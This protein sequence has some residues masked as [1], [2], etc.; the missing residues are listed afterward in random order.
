MIKT[1]KFDRKLENKLDKLDAKTKRIKEKKQALISRIED[2][3]QR[4]FGK[5]EQTEVNNLNVTEE[6]NENIDEESL[7]I[8]IDVNGTPLLNS[9]LANLADSEA[10]EHMMGGEIYLHTW[11][12]INSGKLQWS[13][14]VKKNK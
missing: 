1:L 5:M 8:P 12:I 10:C 14:N 9:S 11:E 2:A 4:Y 13:P 3:E 7:P 6:K